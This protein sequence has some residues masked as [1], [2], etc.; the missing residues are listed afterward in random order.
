MATP[1]LAMEVVG[2]AFGAAAPSGA[3]QDRLLAIIAPAPAGAPAPPT[4]QAICAGEIERVLSALA[5]LD[6]V[7]AGRVLE[8]L[9]A[10]AW[11]PLAAAHPSLSARLAALRAA[12]LPLSERLAA[13]PE[14]E[15]F[16]ALLQA[17]R[18]DL[19]RFMTLCYC[20]AAR[21]AGPLAAQQ[22]L[23]GAMLKHEAAGLQIDPDITVGAPKQA[24]MIIDHLEDPRK[25]AIIQ[26]AVKTADAEDDPG[27]A[28]YLDSFD[29]ASAE[30]RNLVTV[31]L[32]SR[33]VNPPAPAPAP[34]PSPPGHRP[35]D[36][37]KI[38]ACA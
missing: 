35:S 10:G 20:I 11:R 29:R 21:G 28:I 34:L 15:A 17:H 12:M 4:L 38:P 30:I 26:A 16:A 37:T 9:F 14:Y 7:Y 22:R 18:G 36:A 13:A 2:L 19:P 33:A 1:T 8:R 24:G 6:P 27:D 32:R 31:V 25:A 3:A 5:E 23:V